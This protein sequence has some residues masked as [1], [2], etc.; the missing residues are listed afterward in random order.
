[1]VQSS[2]ELKGIMGW[3][4]MILFLRVSSPARLEKVQKSA[5]QHFLS[6]IVW[7]MYDFS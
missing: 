1:M 2:I 5:T 6:G 7:H 4:L 3:T